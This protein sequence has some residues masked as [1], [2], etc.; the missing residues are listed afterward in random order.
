MNKGR[1][2]AY[3]RA[4]DPGYRCP[5]VLTA[6][7]KAKAGVEATSWRRH[8]VLVEPI[9]PLANVM[10][11]IYTPQSMSAAGSAWRR[12]CHADAC[13]AGAAGWAGRQR[14]RSGTLTAF[15]LQVLGQVGV[16]CVDAVQQREGDEV[17]AG[18]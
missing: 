3:L 8:V 9:V 17:R 6:G 1:F 13:S 10:G 2:Q 5:V 18:R 15:L 16:R 14:G 4:A 12:Q 7:Q 11:R